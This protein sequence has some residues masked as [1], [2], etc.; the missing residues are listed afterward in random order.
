MPAGVRVGTS[1]CVGNEVATRVGEV[2]GIREVS[3]APGTEG[4]MAIQA[5]KNMHS[6][7]SVEEVFILRILAQLDFTLTLHRLEN[8]SMW[9]F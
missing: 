9:T 8:A 1:G 2:V 7:K 6:Q 4:V 5:L 3:L